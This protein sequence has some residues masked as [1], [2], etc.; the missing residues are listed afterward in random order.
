LLKEEGKP[1]S[2][3]GHL[4]KVIERFDVNDTGFNPVCL[5]NR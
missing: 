1:D 5:F 2:S 3:Y 4:A